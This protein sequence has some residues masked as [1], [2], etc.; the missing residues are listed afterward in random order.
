MNVQDLCSEYKSQHCVQKIKAFTM[1][2][3]A[4]GLRCRVC[5]ARARHKSYG[6]LCC[7]PCRVFFRRSCLR[8]KI[9]SMRKCRTGKDECKQT[10]AW[11][12]SRCRFRRCLAAGLDPELVQE[13]GVRSRDDHDEVEDDPEPAQ[14][15]Q[16]SSSSSDR[17][18]VAARSR[19]NHRIYELEMCFSMEED[20]WI[21]DIFQRHGT[22]CLNSHSE[23]LSIVRFYYFM[24]V[25]GLRFSSLRLP[26]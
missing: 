12:C 15:Q 8:L 25:L 14:Q 21:N 6:S 26:R 3:P 18:L 10:D 2:S 5:H 20:K 17:S 13:D 24:E 4:S 16:Q 19:L 9:R 11:N 23:H 7:D 22:I 1:D